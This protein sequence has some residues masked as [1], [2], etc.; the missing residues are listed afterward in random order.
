MESISMPNQ[1]Q[2]FALFAALNLIAFLLYGT[3][4]LFA[5]ANRSRISEKALLLTSALGASPGALIG[6][7]VFNHKT[8]KPKFRYGVPALL[9]L[10]SA[11]SYWL[12][13]S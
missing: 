10:H 1:Q 13:Y 3:D 8:S 7:V 6:M 5:K 9:A 2:L 12:S 11:A 4:K